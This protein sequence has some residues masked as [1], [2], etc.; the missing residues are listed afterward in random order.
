LELKA[1]Y[2]KKYDA[3]I[4]IMGDDW[5]GG[6]DWVSKQTDCAVM[7]LPRTPDISTTLL[8]SH[9]AIIEHNVNLN[10]N[11][12]LDMTNVRKEIT[13]LFNL[14]E[15]INEPYHL[16]N[17]SLIG[18]MR[19]RKYV[20]WEN[21]VDIAVDIDSGSKVCDSIRKII[22]VST[23]DNSDIR[24]LKSLTSSLEINI[25]FVKDLEFQSVVFDNKILR[26]PTNSNLL[27]FKMDDNNKT[28]ININGTDIE[29]ADR[30]E[31]VYRC[32]EIVRKRFE[33]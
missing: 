32:M 17:R 5:E 33:N 24:T 28:I 4:V 16:T 10:K 19:D 26:I 15:S 23:I 3:N 6:F 29:F 14:L 11:Y 12:F 22:E 20:P 18:Y 2:I 7:Y 8:K 31:N 21:R 25:Y 30:W 13:L 9:I 27:H 1:E